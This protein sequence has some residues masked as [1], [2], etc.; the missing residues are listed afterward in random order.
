MSGPGPFRSRRPGPAPHANRPR[1]NPAGHRPESASASVA[2]SP[3]RATGN[4]RASGGRNDT[5][6]IARLAGGSRTTASPVLNGEHVHEDVLAVLLESPVGL[7]RTLRLAAFGDDRL[8]D[9]L[10]LRVNSLPQRPERIAELTLARVGRGPGPRGTRLRS[11]RPRARAPRLRVR[12]GGSAGRMDSGDT[13]RKTDEMASQPGRAHGNNAAR[14]LRPRPSRPGGNRSGASDDANGRR[15]GR[16]VREAM[17]FTP[18]PR[19]RVVVRPHFWIGGARHAPGCHVPGQQFRVGTRLPVLVAAEDGRHEVRS[20][21][22]VEAS[23]KAVGVLLLFGLSALGAAV[24]GY[25]V[26]CS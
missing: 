1:G 25:R 14:A 7:P 17:A 8:L 11:G 3:S 10:L 18:H 20:S 4:S 5:S 12:P 16:M 15:G 23:Y 13:W 9:F 6:D 2:S 21:S 22:H 19:V 24:L 26:F